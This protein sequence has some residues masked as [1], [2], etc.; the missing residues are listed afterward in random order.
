MRPAATADR[1]RAAKIS[2]S[3][4]PVPQVMWNRGTLVPEPSAPCPPRSGHTGRG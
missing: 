1:T 4:G 2:T 3:P